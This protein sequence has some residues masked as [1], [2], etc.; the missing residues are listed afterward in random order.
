MP[1]EG[2]R[3]G[4][5]DKAELS[6]ASS[7]RWCDPS[8]GRR[9]ETSAGKG[10]LCRITLHA[11]VEMAPI[12]VFRLMTAP[13]NSPA[14]RDI[15][16]VPRHKVLTDDGHGKRVVEMEQCTGFKFLSFPISFATRLVMET[17][18][19]NLTIKFRLAKKGPM[20][21]F[22]GVWRVC[23]AEGGR[24]RA[25]IVELEQDVLPAFIPPFCGGFLRGVSVRAIRR[26]AEDLDAVALRLGGGETLE[27][28]LGG[29]AKSESVSESGK[30]IES[31]PLAVDCDLSD[32]EG[33]IAATR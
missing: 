6:S 17:D 7:G 30:R 9:I 15:Y 21:V 18:E 16:S 8:S 19:G 29:A 22:Q 1:G 20:K 32:E 2:L 23:E 31:F 5:A 11:R 25:S 14:F 13:D 4:D 10:V 28:V 12:D 26:V 3:V 27:G 24:G 33:E